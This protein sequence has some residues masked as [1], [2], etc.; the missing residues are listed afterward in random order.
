MPVLSDRYQVQLPILLEVSIQPFQEFRPVTNK[1]PTHRRHVYADLRAYLCTHEECG[2]AMFEQKHSWIDHEMEKHWRSWFCCL[3]KFSSDQQSEVTMHLEQHHPE[4]LSTEPTDTMTYM[5]SRPLD[6][7]DA[8]RCPLCDWDKSLASR[9][10]V[11][12]VSCASFMGHLAQHLEQLALFAIPRVNSGEA[13]GSLNSNHA[14]NQDSQVSQSTDNSKLPREERSIGSTIKADPTG[15][16]SSSTREPLPGVD[17]KPVSLVTI[18]L[19]A[20][21]RSDDATVAWM[22]RTGAHNSEVVTSK[23]PSRP[24]FGVDLGELFV[25]ERSAVPMVVYQCIQAVELFGL[26]N[27]GIYRVPGTE[28]HINALRDVFNNNRPNLDFRNPANFHHDIN[29]V[30]AVLKQFFRDLPEPLLTNRAYDT[31]ISAARFEDAITRRDA[32]H[33]QINDL[34]DANYATL[35]ALVLHLYRVMQNERKN[36]MSSTNLAICFAYV[37]TYLYITEIVLTHLT[38]LVY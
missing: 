16:T 6:Y 13:S 3:C 19:L 14:A 34:P 28:A 22:D 1:S 29:S 31:F 37:S 5:T 38:D 25:R 24:V 15:S 23:A 32:L 30:A 17:S 8:S 21:P 9:N 10:S 12:T 35:R 20:E 26:E 11:T 33:E 7:L 18:R 2:M 27:E 4:T 36:R